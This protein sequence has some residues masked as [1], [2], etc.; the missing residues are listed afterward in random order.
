MMVD[1][2][3]GWKTELERGPDWLYVKLYGPYG[4]RADAAGLAESLCMLMHQDRVRR[5]VLEL[6]GLSELPTD[7][8]QELF[9]LLELIDD[10]GG[11]L[12]LCGLCKRHR[13]VLQRRDF[14]HRFTPFRTR[15][16]A[17]LGLH[18]PNLPR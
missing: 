16:D 8:L 13:E 15:N 10:D 5:M 2:A 7:F 14:A 12:R 18:R 17:V 6:D 9:Q 11:L 3:P 1:L 4:K